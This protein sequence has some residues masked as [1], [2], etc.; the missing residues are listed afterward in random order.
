MI[1]SNN[2]IIVQ[3]FDVIKWAKTMPIDGADETK[4]IIDEPIHL[5]LEDQKV[6]IAMLV[7]NLSVWERDN[8]KMSVDLKFYLL[9]KSI[10][11][12]L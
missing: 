4:L 12:E 8:D 7:E 5:L 6:N 3:S 10:A 2:D 11:P 1:F 9:S